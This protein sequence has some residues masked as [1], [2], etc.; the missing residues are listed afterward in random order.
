MDLQEFQR[1]FDPKAPLRCRW[2]SKQLNDHSN[3]SGSYCD[4]SCAAAA[5]PQQ[6]KCDKCQSDKG[7]ILVEV[8]GKWPLNGMSRCQNCQHTEKQRGGIVVTTALVEAEAIVAIFSGFTA[9]RDSRVESAQKVFLGELG[10]ASR[11]SPRFEHI[12][13]QAP[14][15]IKTVDL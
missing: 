10:C 9:R 14:L 3:N 15:C 1:V 13:S 4:T 12:R 2:C 7:H 8:P 6:F 11:A 5:N